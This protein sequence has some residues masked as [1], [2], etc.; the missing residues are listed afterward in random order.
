MNYI[1]LNY[2]LG[3]SDDKCLICDILYD[4]SKTRWK[5]ML[6][7]T[8]ITE[9]MAKLLNIPQ[10]TYSS[11]ESGYRAIPLECLFY[12]ALNFSISLDFLTGRKNT[13]RI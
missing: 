4:V 2:L 13:E 5:I 1:S 11:Y 9:R 10:R 6:Y 12:F 3:F 7:K 8:I